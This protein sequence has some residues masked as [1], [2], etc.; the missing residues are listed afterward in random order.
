MPSPSS[1]GPPPPHT[2]RSPPTPTPPPVLLSV[3]ISDGKGRHD[4]G[5]R[6]GEVHDLWDN[7]RVPEKVWRQ[8]QGRAAEES[9]ASQVST[10]TCKDSTKP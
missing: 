6:T 3:P 2:P 10:I 1:W 7:L 8:G 4:C 5:H 9:H